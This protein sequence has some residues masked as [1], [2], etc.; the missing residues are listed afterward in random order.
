MSRAKRTWLIVGAVALIVIALNL[1]AQALD[2]ATGGDGPTGVTGSSYATKDDGL[3][4]YA[5]LLAHFGHSVTRQRGAFAED[6]PPPGATVVMLDPSVVTT[7]DTDALLAFVSGGGHLVIGG[8]DP[9]YLRSLRDQPPQWS[10][11]GRSTWALTGSASGSAAGNA[12][13]VD[14]AARGSWVAPGTSTPLVGT[15]D[16]ALLTMEH[17]GEGEM[18]F[19]AD[20]SPLEN[21][22]LGR[23]DNAAFGLALVGDRPVVF[24]EG[25]HGYG[26]QRGINAI[27]TPWK[28]ALLLGAAAA[29]A[30]RL[31]AGAPLRA[32]RHRNART[33][34]RARRV[35]PIAFRHA[36]TD[37][38]S[39]GGARFDAGLHA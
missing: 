23:A 3:A 36:R 18:M 14:A 11:D 12:Q 29:L 32:A 2:R 30:L 10:P 9:Y 17:V 22:Y 34:P 16:D 13:Q 25:V 37:A 39:R 15:S 6:E 5:A 7:S 35:R 19:L 33:S 20:G 21:A 4:A 26:K 1:A 28:A 31:V 24:A 38:R 8:N 27:P